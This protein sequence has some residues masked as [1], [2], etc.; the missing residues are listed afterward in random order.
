MKWRDLILSL[1][2]AEGVD[3]LQQHQ[4]VK[5][6]ER[7][8]EI[9]R[10]VLEVTLHLA[11]TTVAKPARQFGLGMQILNHYRYSFF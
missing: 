10:R 2:E 11:E 5:E 4:F 8:R 6:N 9:F 1:E 7:R 3:G